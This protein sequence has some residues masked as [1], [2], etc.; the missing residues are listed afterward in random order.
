MLIDDDISNIALFKNDTVLS[1]LM[2]QLIHHGVSHIRFKIENVNEPHSLDEI[3]DVLLD[4]SGKE[5]IKSSSTKFVN[6]SF[7]L[8]LVLWKSESEMDVDIDVGVI[9]GWA[10][11][12]WSIVVNNIFGK[13]A[14][15]SL[16]EAVAPVG[17]SL[18][19]TS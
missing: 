14:C 1:K 15:N 19:Y 16:V 11:L 8:L 9:F 3:S 5:L 18:H 12:N 2:V 10:S 7:N 17:T 4:F 13:H 6:E